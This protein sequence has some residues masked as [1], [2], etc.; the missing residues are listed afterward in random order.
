[1]NRFICHHIGFAGDAFTIF[2]NLHATPNIKYDVNRSRVRTS[3]TGQLLNWAWYYPRWR[4]DQFHDHNLHKQL[5]KSK[6][7][8]FWQAHFLNREN[9]LLTKFNDCGT[10]ALLATT[11]EHA[12]LYFRHGHAK[13]SDKQLYPSWFEVQKKNFPLTI[14]ENQQLAE[15]L[16][17]TGLSCIEYRAI[18]YGDMNGR[19]VTD[20]Y[21]ELALWYNDPYITTF[22]PNYNTVLHDNR[23]WR[24]IFDEEKQAKVYIDKLIDPYTHKLNNEYY[25]EVC[26]QLELTPNLEL[27][28]DFWKWWIALQP[29]VDYV[30]KLPFRIN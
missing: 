25:V 28:N 8:N 3:T 10:I 12:D 29:D 30:P 15:K 4:E 26:E 17:T 14:K 13:L 27:Y 21:E 18:F 5:F 2:L 19:I 24:A 11:E 22:Q 16:L 7:K 20:I 6:D 23:H 1:M 9:D